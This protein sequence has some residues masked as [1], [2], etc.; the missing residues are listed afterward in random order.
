[1]ACREQGMALA[2]VLF[3]MALLMLLAL[4]LTDKVQQTTRS[5]S[6]AQRQTRNLDAASAGIAWARRQLAI[7]YASSGCWHDFLATAPDTG[8]YPA[9]PTF[10]LEFDGRFVELFVRDNPDGDDNWQQDNDLQLF[11]LA[12]LPAEPGPETLV[13]ALCGFTADTA[14]GDYQQ[15]QPGVLHAGPGEEPGPASDFQLTD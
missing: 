1:M 9:T 5:T 13:E 7:R 2:S 10:S 15:L 11:L 3:I 8:S 12:R 4:V 6:M 14:P